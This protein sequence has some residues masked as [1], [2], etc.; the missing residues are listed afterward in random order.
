MYGV[1]MSQYVQLCVDTEHRGSLSQTGIRNG[2]LN[3]N[4]RTVFPLIPIEM[5]SDDAW[6]DFLEMATKNQGASPSTV[7]KE[8]ND[9]RPF[10]FK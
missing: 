9:H 5:E 4:C 10:L 1:R 8:I 7:S 6:S 2:S 3:C